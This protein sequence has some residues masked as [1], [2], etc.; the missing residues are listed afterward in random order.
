MYVYIFPV[1]FQAFYVASFIY[2]S[3]GL[4]KVWLTVIPTLEMRKL[5]HRDTK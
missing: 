2:F 1:V 4:Y 5:R 3:Q